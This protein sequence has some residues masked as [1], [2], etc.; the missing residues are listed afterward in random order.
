MALT[1]WISKLIPSREPEPRPRV[2][3]VSAP[4]VDPPVREMIDRLEEMP[5]ELGEWCDTPTPS[6]DPAECRSWLLDELHN[7]PRPARREDGI[8]LLLTQLHEVL[9]QENLALPPPPRAALRLFELLQ[10]EEVSI[11]SVC[12]ELRQE[13][14]LVRRVWAQASSAHFAT[15]P[16]DLQYAVARVGLRELS[17]IAAAEV[18]SARTFSIQ[19][20]KTHAEATRLRSILASELASHCTRGLNSEAYLSSLLHAVGS[21]IVLRT[22]P[23]ETPPLERMMPTILRR[24]EAPLGMLTLSTWSMP[25]AVVAAVGYQAD[26]SKAP[27]EHRALTRLTR[28]TSIASHGAEMMS[29]RIDAGALEALRALP[30]LETDPAELLFTADQKR[31]N[32]VR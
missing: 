26:P 22:V 10:D 23:I 3:V 18:V 17:R 12:E 24:L 8:E 25:A 28:A 9:S 15:P 20:L 13:P 19:V 11:H 21:L 27:L 6:L 14:A 30:E 16:R 1:A 29:R 4:E 31:Q 7:L 5:K 2:A 32:L